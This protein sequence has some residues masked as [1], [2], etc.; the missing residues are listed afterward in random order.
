MENYR[1]ERVNKICEDLADL[2]T[3]RSLPITSWQMKE[4]FFLTPAE[5]DTAPADQKGDGQT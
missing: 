5:A 1:F 2:S 4:G 3:I